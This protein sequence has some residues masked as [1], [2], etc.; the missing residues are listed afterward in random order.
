MSAK[1]NFGTF[2]TLMVIYVMIAYI[3]AVPFFLISFYFSR[4]YSDDCYASREDEFTVP[5]SG[6]WLSLIPEDWRNVSERYRML[7]KWNLINLILPVGAALLGGLR[8]WKC[9]SIGFITRLQAYLFLIITFS[10]CF[11]LIYWFETR[12]D[13]SGRVCSGDFNTELSFSDHVTGPRKEPYEYLR[14]TVVFYCSAIIDVSMALLCG[15]T[16]IAGNRLV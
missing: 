10:F 9:A 12:W 3:V 5:M 13:H 11:H 7:T 15:S 1:K 6:V 2:S 14:G 8:E 4:N 16:F